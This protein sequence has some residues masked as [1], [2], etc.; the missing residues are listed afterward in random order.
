M[1]ALRINPRRAELVE[2]WIIRKHLWQIKRGVII[3][4]VIFVDS[5]NISF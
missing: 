5:A 3:N 1:I 4:L 2:V